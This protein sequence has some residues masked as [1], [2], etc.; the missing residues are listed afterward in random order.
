M[1]IYDVLSLGAF[2]SNQ[3]TVRCKQ[4]LLISKM[5]AKW[6]MAWIFRS[7]SKASEM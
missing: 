7:Q 3:F 4:E 2:V 6:W 1:C 5:P